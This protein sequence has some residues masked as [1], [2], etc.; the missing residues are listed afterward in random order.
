[1]MLKTLHSNFLEW[2]DTLNNGSAAQESEAIIPH[3]D[4]VQRAFPNQPRQ[5]VEDTS[6]LIISKWKSSAFQVDA[7]NELKLLALKWRR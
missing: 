7:I 5:E 3:L 2:K 6:G 1:M 4:Y